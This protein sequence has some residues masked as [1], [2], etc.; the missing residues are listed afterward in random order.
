MSKLMKEA[1]MNKDET[2]DILSTVRNTWSHNREMSYPEAVYHLNS[3][4]LF[5]KS[6]EV[7]Y[8]ACDYP[9]NRVRSLKLNSEEVI[10]DNI[11][12]DGII[13]YYQNRPIDSHFESMP[14][15]TFA[16]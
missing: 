14:L 9:Q 11:F 3:L 7:V 6:R 16:A 8:L 1:L 2:V 13:E 12:N 5:W 10:G 4:P 15:I